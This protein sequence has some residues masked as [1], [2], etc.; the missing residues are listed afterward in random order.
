MPQTLFRS[1][2]Y[3]SFVSQRDAGLERITQHCQIDLSRILFEVLEQVDRLAGSLAFKS[4]VTHGNDM[5]TTLNQNI[6]KQFETGTLDIFTQSFPIFLRRLMSQR[7]AVFTLVYA[8]EL[9]AIG[10]GTQRKPNLTGADF[11][12]ALKRSLSEPTIEG[13][14]DKRVW[15]ALMTL[16]RK[17]I[18]Q[19]EIG[20]TQELKPDEVVSRMKDFSFP[21][22]Q[23]YKRPPK[24]LTKL[25]ESA[26]DPDD[27]HD[28]IDLDFID[29]GDW[30]MMVDAYTTTELPPSRFDKSA[31]W[32]PDSGLMKYNWEL[33]Q[34]TTEDFVRAARSGQVKAAND[35]GVQDFVW[36]AVIDDKTCD[37]CC[38]PRNGKTT[39][40]IEEMDDDCGVTVPPAHFNCRC[41]IMP[42]ASVNQVSGPQ[43][44]DFE[45]WLAKGREQ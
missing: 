24:T 30:N 18:H 8:S 1:G 36:V 38:L 44:S 43:M 9:E 28:W 34:E 7:R 42:V 27:T 13:P 12:F 4:V 32:D 19:F 37:D 40:E 25:K 20:I 16:R 15:H 31:Q 22:L 11:R 17:I 21:K 33:E 39:S 14:L 10:R 29:D 2:Q 5:H 45:D 3:V 6:S 35:I 41:Q 23:V 26:Q